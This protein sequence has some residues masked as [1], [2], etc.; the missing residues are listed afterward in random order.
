[1]VSVSAPP[2][3][4]FGTYGKEKI[5]SVGRLMQ[6][7]EQPTSRAAQEID[8]ADL[9]AIE[10]SSKIIKRVICPSK[11]VSKRRNLFAWTI[12]TSAISS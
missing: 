3:P 12:G 11:A 5:R 4:T 6:N 1:M 10:K 7:L 2:R 8:P 9:S